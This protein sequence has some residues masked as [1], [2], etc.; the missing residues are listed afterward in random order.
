MEV[1]QR[2]ALEAVKRAQHAR[3][4]RPEIDLIAL[5]L[6]GKKVDFSKVIKLIDEMVGVLAKE[7]QDDDHKKEYCEKSLDLTEDKIKEL[8][9]T[10]SDL[11]TQIADTKEMIKTLI[12][13]IK[14]LTE[15]I[16]KLDKSV[17][18]A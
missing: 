11:E 3:H 10:I 8:K 12:D 17:T 4:R 18:E 7:Q 2:R 16:T 6:T 15:G 9:H 1:A 13:E 5:A 14:A